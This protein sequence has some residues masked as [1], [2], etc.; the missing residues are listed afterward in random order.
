VNTSNVLDDTEQKIEIV[1]DNA[2]VTYHSIAPW[3]IQWKDIDSLFNYISENNYQ[4]TYK[5]LDSYIY[6]LIMKVN[7][8]N[9]SFTF[10]DGFVES[11]YG[12][13]VY[14]SAVFTEDGYKYETSSSNLDVLAYFLGIENT[15]VY[16]ILS[17]KTVK[18]NIIETDN[19]R[20]EQKLAYID[21]RY[22][23]TEKKTLNVNT[24]YDI[25]NI[26]ANKISSGELFE[27]INSYNLLGKLEKSYLSNVVS[28]IK[29]KN[30]NLNIEYMVLPN[31]YLDDDM[32]S[33]DK[34][35]RVYN[36][37]LIN[38]INDLEYVLN[39]DGVDRFNV[40]R[41][42]Y[43]AVNSWTGKKALENQ[44]VADS[45]GLRFDTLVDLIEKNQ[46]LLND[47]TYYR[48]F[49]SDKYENF[50]SVI[51]SNYKFS[52]EQNN[53]FGGGN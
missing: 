7:K 38:T 42:Y 18:I 32:K 2:A 6:R 34:Q 45:L 17:D 44:T 12:T 30:V 5:N 9:I 50:V 53:I 1:T 14:Y 8:D 40:K 41:N 51:K 52:V 35:Y 26:L 37:R 46:T 24:K 13:K 27:D 36:L 22:I 20:I 3:V 29:D 16:N 43:F 10:P 49:K 4:S 11:Q 15:N 31:W 25:Y 47:N 39:L 48:M 21:G 19:A 28:G 33:V 23:V